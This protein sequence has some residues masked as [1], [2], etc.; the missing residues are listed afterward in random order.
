MDIRKNA[1]VKLEDGN[2]YIVVEVLNYREKD[3]YYLLGTQEDT[4]LYAFCEKIVDGGT[5]FFKAIEDSYTTKKI[6]T[7]FADKL[8]ENQV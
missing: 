8:R 2:Q 5:T 4:L 3:Y 1:I 7:L 6:A